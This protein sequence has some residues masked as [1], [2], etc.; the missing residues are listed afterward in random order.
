MFVSS[1]LTVAICSVLFFLHVFFLY[2][3]LLLSLVL[4]VM[5]NCLIIIQRGSFG[6]R[7]I[8]IVKLLINIKVYMKFLYR[9]QFLMIQSLNVLLFVSFRDP[10]QYRRVC[11]RGESLG[12]ADDVQMCCR[13]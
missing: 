4:S 13:R 1:S 11:G 2:I 10:L 8:S 12:L 5:I 7:P 9:F 3:L 6:A